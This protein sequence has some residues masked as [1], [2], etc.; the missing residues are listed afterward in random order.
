MML[1]Q[2]KG[3]QNDFHGGRLIK[4]IRFLVLMLHNYW[5]INIKSEVAKLKTI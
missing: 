4:K 1:M 2:K 3:L 5:V